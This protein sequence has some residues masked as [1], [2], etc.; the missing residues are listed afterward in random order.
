MGITISMYR[1]SSVMWKGL[2]RSWPR[3]DTLS[4][5]AI[6]TVWKEQLA[7]AGITANIEKVPVDVFYTD[8][9]LECDSGIVD[10]GGRAY[11]QP[12]LMLAY[13][14]DS[15]WN[16]THLCDEELDELAL[17]AAKEMDHAKRVEL[18]HKIQEIFIE[19]GGMIV[20]Y[21][22]AGIIAYRTDVKPGL[23]P[24][25]LTAAVDFRRVWLES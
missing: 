17:A 5:A 8:L 2:R 4:A 14:C 24:C 16:S 7:E 6:A 1:N 10:W 22:F 12:Y 21:F 18:Y 20:P 9:W 13:M 19:R 25:A 15:P 3:L 23:A 11:P